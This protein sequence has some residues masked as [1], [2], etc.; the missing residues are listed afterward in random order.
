MVDDSCYL[1]FEIFVEN[2]KFKMLARKWQ[3]NV[4]KYKHK[5]CKRN[6]NANSNLIYSKLWTWLFAGSL[7]MNCGRKFE[8]IANLKNL[9]RILL[10]TIQFH[11]K[12][13]FR[14]IRIFGVDDFL[15]EVWKF[16]V[17]NLQL[18]FDLID[19]QDLVVKWIENSQ[20]LLEIGKFKMAHSR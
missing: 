10:I 11:F 1:D 17:T 4:A 14:Y 12:A 13:E 19:I 6:C 9:G 15:V 8:K 16:K 18:W 3:T 5:F 7:I 20:F 2:S